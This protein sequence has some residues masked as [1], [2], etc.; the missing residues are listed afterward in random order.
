MRGVKRAKRLYF[1]LLFS[2]IALAAAS[3]WLSMGPSAYGSTREL[4]RFLVFVATIAVGGA[5][6]ATAVMI[7]SVYRIVWPLVAATV[8]LVAALAATVARWMSLR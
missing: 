5:T 8:T 3:T 4:V 6:W 7:A 1:A 2:A